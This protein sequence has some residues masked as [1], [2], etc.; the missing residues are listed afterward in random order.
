MCQKDAQN[1]TQ[2]YIMCHWLHVV[3]CVLVAVNERGTRESQSAKPFTTATPRRATEV[4]HTR[5]MGQAHRDTSSWPEL[6]N[7]HDGLQ[8]RPHS[9]V[10]QWPSRAVSWSCQLGRGRASAEPECNTTTVRSEVLRK[11]TSMR[12]LPS[13][14]SLNSVTSYRCVR[15]AP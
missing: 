8:R 4:S 5:C 6:Q 10:K 7:A 1:P 15:A 14:R 3:P 2:A 12:A 13:W 9:P 11:R